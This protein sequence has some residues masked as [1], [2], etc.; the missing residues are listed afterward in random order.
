MYMLGDHHLDKER[1]LKQ[2]RQRHD[3]SNSVLEEPHHRSKNT[4][5][6]QK[7]QDKYRPPSYHGVR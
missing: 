1:D 5:I 2:I 3:F 7:Y 6:T 4:S